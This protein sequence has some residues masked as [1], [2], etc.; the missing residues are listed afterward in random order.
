MITS[1]AGSCPICK[2]PV[3]PPFFRLADVPT[4][5]G[6]VGESLEEALACPV[7]DVTLCLCPT[8]GWIGNMTFDP[9]KLNYEKFHF[10]LQHSP[11]FESFVSEVVD[12]LTRKYDL[13][14]KKVLDVGCGAGD[15]LKTFARQ[16]QINGLGIDPSIISGTEKFERGEVSL[17]R[18]ILE[19][20]HR[21]FDAALICCRHVL[22]SMPDPLG[23]LQ[24]IRAVNGDRPDTVFY[25]EV[26]H[27]GPTFDNDLVWNVAYEH[28]SWFNEV[29]FT[30]LCERA[31]FEVL[32][33]GRC[34]RDEYLFAELRGGEPNQESVAPLEA[35]DSQRANLERFSLNVRDHSSRWSRRLDQFHQ[36]GQKVAIWGAG[37]RALLFLLQVDNRHHVGSVV[38]INPSRQGNFLTHLGVRI[39]A[40]E[41]LFEFQPDVILIS[42]SAF[43][44]EIRAQAAALGLSAET[45][46][47]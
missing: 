6:A 10:S 47:F 5:D 37:A 18:G 39:D 38:D 24:Q 42:N 41:S 26:P 4:L 29:S 35:V 36:A 2:N 13:E 31:G 28:R 14:G 22:N 30:T 40:P 34:W 44:D 21:D 25:L 11:V 12:N 7:G 45:E 3:E 15:F 19:P 33:I 9:S 17:Q 32:D 27:A 46:V 20:H 23:L 8:C 1:N 43:A 16:V